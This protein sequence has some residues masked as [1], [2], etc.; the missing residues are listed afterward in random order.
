M[1]QTQQDKVMCEMGGCQ[2]SEA[3]CKVAGAICL[4][5]ATHLLGGQEERCLRAAQ[6]MLHSYASHKSTQWQG[7]P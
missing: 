5:S 6:A 3:L 4:C 1:P 2:K 7:L